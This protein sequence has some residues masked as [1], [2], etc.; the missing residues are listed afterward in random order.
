MTCKITTSLYEKLPKKFRYYLERE[1]EVFPYLDPDYTIIECDDLEKVYYGP[2]FNRYLNILAE[3]YMSEGLEPIAA[4]DRHREVDKLLDDENWGRPEPKIEKQCDFSQGKDLAG[5]WSNAT[6]SEVIRDIQQS[7]DNLKE[8]GFLSAK[9]S[10]DI[11]KFVA[12]YY[13]EER[14]VPAAP[15]YR[16]VTVDHP[17][18][19]TP[20]SPPDWTTYTAR[21]RLAD[22][23]EVEIPGPS[24]EGWSLEYHGFYLTPDPS[25]RITHPE[26][27]CWLHDMLKLIMQPGSECLTVYKW[28]YTPPVK[29]S[30]PGAESLKLLND[31]PTGSRAQWP[32]SGRPGGPVR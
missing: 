31:T 16:C 23:R 15:N 3:D 2:Y 29:P 24:E 12:V 9:A 13:N 19:V 20:K 6:P 32:E 25:C 14:Y 18:V 21:Y 5:D 10:G 26:G 27:K 4:Y 1:Y 28:T 30:Y 11:D 22:G 8:R 17:G 7:W